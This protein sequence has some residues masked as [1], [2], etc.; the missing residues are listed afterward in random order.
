MEEIHTKECTL[1]HHATILASHREKWCAILGVIKCT[2]SA[3]S[4]LYVMEA[5][6]EIN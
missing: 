4:V 6:S 3:H 1:P 2:N 5:D